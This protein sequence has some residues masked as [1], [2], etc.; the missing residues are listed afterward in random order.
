MWRGGRP[1]PYMGLERLSTVSTIPY[2][3][4]V[5]CGMKGIG[6]GG[7]SLSGAPM[8]P[9]LPGTMSSPPWRNIL[10][11]SGINDIVNKDRNLCFR[12][13]GSKIRGE[14]QM[15]MMRKIFCDQ[16]SIYSIL[17]LKKYRG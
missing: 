10:T 9:G 11:L 4:Y 15:V 13:R 12:F 7:I 17:I 16:N 3:L 14:G 6:R 2:S 1:K 5:R 8:D